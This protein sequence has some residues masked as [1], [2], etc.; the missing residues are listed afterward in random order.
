MFII[1]GCTRVPEF[2]HQPHQRNHRRGTDGQ[3]PCRYLFHKL[4]SIF[5]SEFTRVVVDPVPEDPYVFGPP[6]SGS[7]IILYGSG[8]FHQQAKKLE[9]PCF[10]LF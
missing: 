10:L 8:S 9:K 2:P 6:G 4:R 7:V 5:R 3:G 1:L